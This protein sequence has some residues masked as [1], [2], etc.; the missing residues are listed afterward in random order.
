MRIFGLIFTFFLFSSFHF[1]INAQDTI[2]G[3]NQ[4]HQ[5]LSKRTLDLHQL[6]NELLQ[7]HVSN[8]G[9]VNY[10]SLKT[11]HEKL[12]SYIYILDL[13]Y[14]SN[15]FQSFSQEEKIAFWINAYNAITVDLIL[16]N[17]P[18]KSIKDIDKPWKQ[19]LWKFGSKMHNLDEI[20]HKILRKM[21]E[22]RIHFA[23]VC[24][25][26]S[27]PKL[28]N[29]AFT[30][31]SLDKDLTKLTKEFLADP[32]KNS[33]SEEQVE[34]SK[35]FQWFTGDFK[36]KEQSLIDFLNLYSEI[37]ISADAKVKFKVYNWKLN[38]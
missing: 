10:K 34:I 37:Q 28:Y 16:R 17:Y 27:C 8:S 38:E 22:P 1:K 5:K 4:F 20:E 35:I 15:S 25:A 36:T 30:P 33:I 32:S 2:Q 3:N 14:T 21:N 26:I 24:A 18:V 12:L 9:I 11:E 23:L 6:W 31:E 13:A 7:K 19:K 29:K